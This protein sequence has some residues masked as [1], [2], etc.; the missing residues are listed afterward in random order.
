MWQVIEAKELPYNALHDQGYD[1]IGCAT[2]TAPGA[3]RAG[4]WAGTDKL[5]CG[6]HVV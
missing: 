3:G 6:L 1:S 2:C 4:R 5:E